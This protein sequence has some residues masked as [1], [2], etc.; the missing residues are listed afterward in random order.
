MCEYRVRRAEEEMQVARLCLDS[1]HYND[2][3]GRSCYAAF[4]AIKAILAL[5]GKDFATHKGTLGYFNQE[6][7]RQRGLFDKNIGR[8]LARL[9]NKR[10]TYEY[11]D[12]VYATRSE[13]D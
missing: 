11:D 8:D 13:A 3:M 2:A 6:Y 10:E 4:Q 5:E 7:I 1:E 12:L 9:K